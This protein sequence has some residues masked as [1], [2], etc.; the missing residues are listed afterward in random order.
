MRIKFWGTRG[1][2]ACPSPN[3]MRYGG[4]TSCLEVE[5]GDHLVILDA[6]TGIRPLGTELLKRG[7][8]AAHI[9]LTHTH[10]DHINGFPFFAPA[11]VPSGKFHVLAGHL[12][13][14]GGIEHVFDRQMADPTF[15]VPL[16]AMQSNPK[17]EDF[18]AGDRFELVPGVAVRTCPLNHPNGATA[19]RI[20][21]AGKSLCYITDTEHVPGVHDQHILD[22]IEGADLVVYDST[23]TEA[24]FPTKVGWGHSTWNEGMALC[25]LAG[26]R[27][28]G[29]FHH[30]PGHEDD[31]MD[32]LSA[33]ANAAWPDHVVVCRDFLEIVL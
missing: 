5:T 22:L 18:K 8:G 21:H 32:K 29:I 31:F 23:Y 3:H 25:K 33:E 27:K 15:P 24:E 26:A 6:G 9:L 12:T 28:L 20:D 14:Q 2:I 16:A 19:Y 17:F 7:V 10:W 13:G 4:N 1:S 11:Y 30:D